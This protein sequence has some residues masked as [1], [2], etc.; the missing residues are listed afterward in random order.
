MG[1]PNPVN[2]GEASA[3][4]SIMEEGRA[5]VW[6][7]LFQ[8]SF[9]DDGES[10]GHPK[11]NPSGDHHNGG[12]GR[13]E[14]VMTKFA[15]LPVS[16][17]TI[18]ADG[19]PTG[20]AYDWVHKEMLQGDTESSAPYFLYVRCAYLEG[21]AANV[22][23]RVPLVRIGLGM[24]HTFQ[25]NT[26]GC[27]WMRALALFERSLSSTQARTRVRSLSTRLIIDR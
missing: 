14:L 7:V 16:T 9:N 13:H 15:S 19:K 12:K 27:V 2:I 10:G 5:K 23:F 1:A 21:E 22:W 25:K 11:W 26:L 3:V 17:L 24:W 20:Y 6:K 18:Q 8:N 4:V